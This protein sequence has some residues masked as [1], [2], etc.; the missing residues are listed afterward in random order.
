MLCMSEVPMEYWSM[1]CGDIPGRSW[2]FEPYGL[3][4]TK[5]WARRW[6]FNPVWYLN[7]SVGQQWLTTPLNELAVVARRGG[8]V[9]GNPDGTFS[10]VRFRDSQIAKLLPF[11]ETA[12]IGKDFSWEREW[13]RVGSLAFVPGDTVAVLVP[14]ADQASFRAEY[15]RQCSDSGWDPPPLNFVDPKWPLAKIKPAIGM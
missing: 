10:T 15:E 4:F 13:R 3:V 1:L 5:E 8:A 2:R 14:E 7:T 6:S 12:G 9:V 11:I